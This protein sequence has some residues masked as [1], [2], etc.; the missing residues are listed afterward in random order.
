[1]ASADKSRGVRRALRWFEDYARHLEAAIPLFADGGPDP[2]W[3]ARAKELDITLRDLDIECLRDAAFSAEGKVSTASLK[4]AQEGF[5][6]AL[7]GRLATLSDMIS[8][9]RRGQRGLLGYARA[10]SLTRSSALY[11]ERQ[12]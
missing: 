7:T 10:G 5:E 11:I 2:Q 6:A 4:R 3:Q 8:G 1:M 12:F 9:A